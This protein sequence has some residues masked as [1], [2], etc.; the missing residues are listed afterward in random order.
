MRDDEGERS[1]ESMAPLDLPDD[2]G[3]PDDAELASGPSLTDDL[4][5]LFE[6]GKTYAEAEIA[7]QKSRAAF[8][9]DRAR[10]AAGYALL[11]FGFVHLALIA[12][13]VGVL[14]ALIPWIGAWGATAVVTVTLLA[15]AVLLFRLVKGRFDEISSAF[16]ETRQ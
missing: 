15:G 5:A 8:T 4:T 6:D 7:Y 12:A 3:P 11:A 9:A 16:T 14:I 10:G 1:H 2:H 13:T